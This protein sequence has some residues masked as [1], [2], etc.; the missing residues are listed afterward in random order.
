MDRFRQ[1]LSACENGETHVVQNLLEQGIVQVD[2]VDEDETTALQMAAA[3]GQEQ[4]VRLLL[5]KGAALDKANM[6]GWTS[7]MQA[8]RHGHTNVVALLLQNK[9]DI[10]ALNRLGGSAL[11]IAS[12][13]GHLQIVRLL[14]ESGA[15]PNR[16][17]K[18]EKFD[19]KQYLNRFHF[20]YL[21][22]C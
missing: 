18:V 5:M 16:Q 19:V 21:Y 6:A 4:V 7:L 12:R 22:P 8:S 20:L 2:D 3:N 1:L 17:G 15:E 11:T 13:G 9:A 14:L 10:N